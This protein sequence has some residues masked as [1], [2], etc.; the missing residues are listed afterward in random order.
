MQLIHEFS[1]GMRVCKQQ[2]DWYL[3]STPHERAVSWEEEGAMHGVLFRLIHERT[4]GSQM[5]VESV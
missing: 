1:I 4:V 3:A 5:C 2:M